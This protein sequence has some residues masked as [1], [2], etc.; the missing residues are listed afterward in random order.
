MVCPTNTC[1]LSTTF[2]EHS[3]IQNL[4]TA[5]AMGAIAQF[6]V[7]GGSIGLAI[8]T[9]IQHSYLRSH[10]TKFLA[11]NLVEAVLDSSTAIA[12]LTGETQVRVR[13]TYG[14]S[15]NLQMNVLAGLAGAQLLSTLLM[16]QKDPIK[17]K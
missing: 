13:E 14:D 16:I 1:I 7:L 17:A 3:L 6:R 10:L 9:A 2:M 5:V 11:G 15:Y 12:G 8:V 4:P